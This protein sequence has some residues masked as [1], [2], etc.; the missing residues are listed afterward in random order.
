[1][2]HRI[3]PAE[4]VLPG[5]P[6]K[7][8]DAIADALVER[9]AAAE[10]RSL[11]GI[12]VALHMS[13]VFITGRIAG[14]GACDIDIGAVVR[15]VFADAGYSDAWP[16]APECLDIH[17]ALCTGPLKPGESEFRNVADDQSILTGYA[18]DSP[19]TNYLPPE[20]WLAAR[21]GRRLEK[22]RVERPDLNLGPDG[23]LVVLC[24]A[25]PGSSRPSVP[26][27]SRA[28]AADEIE[29]NRAV[30]TAVV[31]ESQSAG[32]ESPVR[33]FVNGAGN[34]EVGGP[35]ATTG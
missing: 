21:L 14:A 34:F 10:Q 9:A 16:P 19:E 4:Y 6:D 11:C 17:T 28:S 8:C 27:C 23:K 26:P 30:R 1:M 12:E 7:L 18:I 3:Y 25:K 2:N 29:L 24:D 15:G 22:L 35:K 31:A 5:H 32:W 33:V 20:H 13:S